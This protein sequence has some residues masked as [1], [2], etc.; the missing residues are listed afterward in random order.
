MIQLFDKYFSTIS[1][2]L[3]YHP[4]TTEIINPINVYS[5]NC[6]NWAVRAYPYLTVTR[7]SYSLFN[8]APYTYIRYQWE[9]QQ[10]YIHLFNSSVISPIQI[11]FTQLLFDDL[12]DH[13]NLPRT[14][15]EISWLKYFPTKVNHYHYVIRNYSTFDLKQLIIKNLALRQLYNLKD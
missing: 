12:I 3:Y 13:R 6:A 5:Q 10:F 9:N 15:N 7:H 4:D 2:K 8:I 1:D 14:N 11:N